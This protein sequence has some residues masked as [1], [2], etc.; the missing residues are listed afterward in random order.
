M[1]ILSSPG[2]GSG[3][4]IN[5]LVQ[6]LVEAE[7]APA[8]QR[9]DRRE[10]D[11]TTKISAFGKF[12]ASY[13]A[14]SNKLSA[15]TIADTFRSRKFTSTS[16]SVL[17]GSADT[18]AATGIYDITVSKL[19]KS[20]SLVTSTS[21]TARTDV[22]GEGT[23]TITFGT[24]P[25]GSFTANPD[26]SPVTIAI[27]STNNTLEGVRDAINAADGGVRASIVN[28]G[29]GYV[30]AL[31]AEDTGA[32]NA[33]KIDVVES[34][35]AGLSALAYNATAQNM[36][37]T[38]AAQDAE[39]AIDGVTV[40]SSGNRVDSAIDGLTL[41]LRDVGNSQVSVSLDTASIQ[42][43]VSAFVKAYNEFRDQLKE[44]TFYNPK[45][46]NAG[47]LN[48]DS[49]VRSMANAIRRYLGDAV[50]GLSGGLRTLADVGI[51][52]DSDGKMQLDTAR[53]QDAIDANPQAVEQLFVGEGDSGDPGYV[54]GIA[55]RLQEYFSQIEKDDLIG[56]RI[57]TL[58][59]KVEDLN[60][61]RERLARRIE[62]YEA[63]LMKQYT[64]LDVLVG[65]LQN[66]SAWL[67]QQLNALP[68]IQVKTGS[69]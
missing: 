63:R 27:D 17:T 49:S 36:Q 26:K 57:N 11:L 3:L 41:D 18:K 54:P 35:P 33:M 4:D 46:R 14:L 19:A 22:V 59:K 60:D 69:K 47:P 44:L 45:T 58:N 25:T 9:L 61:D 52:F 56:S 51:T 40:T 67:Q 50:E 7:R 53:L 6:S 5:S 10:I 21:Y 15:L 62:Q 68:T 28:T 34:G 65:Q 8:A 30:L 64:A 16:E 20:Q 12:K 2:I 42:E 66:T 31:S 23:I 24:D 32:A 48:G 13:S 39:F 1:A 55:S 29:S 37:Q 43:A 38:R